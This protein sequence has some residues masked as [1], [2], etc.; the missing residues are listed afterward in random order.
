VYSI[1]AL[2]RAIE[3]S[4]VAAV[5]ELLREHPE[6]V[7]AT[8]EWGSTPLMRAASWME[9][10]VEVIR[11]ILDAGA[12][13]NRQTSEGYTALHCAIDVDGEANRNAAEV[14]GILVAAGADLKLRQ[15]Y[16]WTPL[17][18]AVVEGGIAEVKALLAAGADPNE[19]MP[20][21]TLPAFNAGR[22]TLMAA[23]A[24]HESLAIVPALLRAGADP[25]MVDAHGMNFFDYA[26]LVQSESPPGDFKT[27]VERCVEIAREW[28]GDA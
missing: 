12:N 21:N 28:R 18:R 25:L 20:S 3:D 11:A 16:G 23:L 5:R 24:N 22:T 2:W 19:T 8:N 1:D 4:D 15:H 14:I 7:E 27:S 6:L 26:G 13:V 9:R 10:K 17:L